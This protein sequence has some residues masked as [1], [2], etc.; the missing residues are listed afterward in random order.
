M[1]IPMTALYEATEPS[2]PKGHRYAVDTVWS[3]ARYGDVLGRIAHDMAHAPSE[4]N[5]ALVVLR[6]NAVDTPTDAAFSC[7]GRIF[8]ALYAIWEDETADAANIGWLRAAIDGTAHLCTGAYVGE[9][10][11]ERP[12]RVLPTLSGSARARLADLR[13]RHDPQGLF[14]RPAPARA[15]AA[16]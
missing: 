16:E 2:T 6:P 8:G 1:P 4:T 11:L 5:M 12:D 7:H 13:A 15:I 9:T 10:D 3:D 14:L